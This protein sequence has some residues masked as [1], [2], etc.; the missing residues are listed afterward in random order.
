MAAASTSNNSPRS[1][2]ALGVLYARYDLS[3]K[4]EA[5]FQEAITSAEY[6]PALVNLGNMRLRDARND[7]ALA[8]YSRAEKQAPQDPFVLLGMA[9]A[10]HELQNFGLAAREYDE[11]RTLNPDLANQFAYLRLQGEESTR[12]AEASQAADVMAWEEEK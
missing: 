3:D 11:L 8:F 9:R 7:D 4:A 2:N 5:E 12:A 1:L 6:T 10:N